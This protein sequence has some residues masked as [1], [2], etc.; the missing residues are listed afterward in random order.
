MK[1]RDSVVCIIRNDKGEILLQKKTLDYARAPGKWSLFGGAAESDNFEKEMNRELKE[2][3]GINMKLK[4]NFDFFSKEGKLYV[5]SSN[6]NDISK[7]S[8]GEGA[9]IAF[10]GEEELK[11]I[12]LLPECEKAIKMFLKKRERHN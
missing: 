9:G 11:D 10:F 8:I 12:K 4:F 6:L 5:F 3:I 7:L 2:E 1:M